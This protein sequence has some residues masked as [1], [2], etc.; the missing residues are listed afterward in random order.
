MKSGIFLLL[1][2]M[3]IEKTTL[4]GITIGSDTAPSRISASQ[5]LNT[6]DRVAGFAALEGGLA[7]ASLSVTA[8][9]DSFFPL[10]GPINLNAGTFL[11]NR[12]LLFADATSVLTLGN[13][14]GRGYGVEFSPTM[15]FIPIN[16]LSSILTFS[17]VF[18]TLNN[19][20][21]LNRTG[22][23]FFGN[24]EINGRGLT[25]DLRSSST[26][27]IAPNSRV[28]LKHVTIQGISGRN[29]NLTASTSRLI[30]QDCT[31]RLNNNYTLTAGGFDVL[32]NVM[33]SGKDVYF[34]YATD[35]VSTVSAYSSLILDSGITF[36]Y[37]PRTNTRDSLIFENSQAQFILN[38]ATFATSTTGIRFRK[39]VLSIE[40][41]CSFVLGNPSKA[42]SIALGDG[43][44]VQNDMTLHLMPG[45]TLIIQNG[46][47]ED[48]N[49]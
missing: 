23:Q 18:L 3:L 8:T 13:I 6:G 10:S 17:N 41:R 7:L 31:L 30:L 14:N 4:Y 47:L 40:G 1:L 32:G 12:D 35:Q 43:S 9:W 26:L 20:I 39:G 28:L 48:D 45:A 36:S 29:L 44:N 24:S 33:I 21:V 5:T 15:T 16:P 22:L 42:G 25:L 11:L 19:D 34:T 46:F 27:Y 49:V 2:L 37:A 38:T